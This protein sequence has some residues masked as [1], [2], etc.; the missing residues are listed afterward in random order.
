VAGVDATCLRRG[1]RGA[2]ATGRD[3][4]DNAFMDKP[5]GSITLN[6]ATVTA[7]VDGHY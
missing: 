1:R 6:D 3:S 4:A 7:V 2:I 5:L